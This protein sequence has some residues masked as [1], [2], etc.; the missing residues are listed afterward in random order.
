MFTVETKTWGKPSNG[1]AKVTFDGAEISVGG[2]QPDRDPIVQAKAQASWLKSMLLESTGKGFQVRPVI[3]FPGWYVENAAGGFR[4]V[5]VLE[6][7]ALPTFLKNETRRLQ[8]E[9]IKLAAFHLSRL[10][11]TT[12]T[13]Q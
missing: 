4:D 5:W 10:I 6:P 12:Q 11:R 8:L 2:L 1:K 7:K 3:V 9:D 13:A